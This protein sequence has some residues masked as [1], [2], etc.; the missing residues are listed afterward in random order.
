MRSAKG[1]A[2]DGV[3]SDIKGVRGMVGTKL[4]V[5]GDEV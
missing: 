5:L 1:R 3:S 2:S 4:E